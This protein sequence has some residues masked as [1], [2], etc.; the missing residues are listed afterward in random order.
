MPCWSEVALYGDYNRFLFLRRGK[1]RCILSAR[2][3]TGNE[4]VSERLVI[5]VLQ[6]CPRYRLK[7]ILNRLWQLELS[8]GLDLAVLENHASNERYIR[9]QLGLTNATDKVGWLQALC[10]ST[11]KAGA[12]TIVTYHHIGLFI[13]RRTKT[14]FRRYCPIGRS[15]LR[16]WV[17]LSYQLSLRYSVSLR[18]RFVAWRSSPDLASHK[19]NHRPVWTHFHHLKKHFQIFKSIDSTRTQFIAVMYWSHSQH[20]KERTRSPCHLQFSLRLTRTPVFSHTLSMLLQRRS[21]FNRLIP[22]ILFKK[23]LLNRIDSCHFCSI[24]MMNWVGRI[25]RLSFLYFERCWVV[26]NAC[27]KVI[28]DFRFEALG[29]MLSTMNAALCLSQRTQDLSEQR[30]DFELMAERENREALMRDTCCPTHSVPLKAVLP[31]VL[32]QN[33]NSSVR[34]YYNYIIYLW[35]RSF[36]LSA[37]NVWADGITGGFVRGE[38]SLSSRGIRWKPDQLSRSVCGLND[39]IEKKHIIPVFTAS[40]WS[41]DTEKQ[42]KVRL[43]LVSRIRGRKDEKIK[44]DILLNALWLLQRDAGDTGWMELILKTHIEVGDVL[45]CLRK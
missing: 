1:D 3:N 15:T 24:F 8:A 10:K 30:I 22:C 32:A 19:S 40:R 11:I 16:S 23:L 39:V 33:I 14:D 36:A 28:N 44:R 20:N 27:R 17:I 13:L 42:L 29:R 2:K 26:I 35:A 45:A 5:I 21:R 18:M 25:T 34:C 4:S 38:L 43:D 37:W 31:F 12:F 6:I 41:A 7:S 9:L